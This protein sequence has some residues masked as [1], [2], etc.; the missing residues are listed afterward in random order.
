MAVT[1]KSTLQN[2]QSYLA[3]LG[4]FTG[5]VRIGEPVNPPEDW[6]AALFMSRKEPSPEGVTLTGTMD[7]RTISVRIYVSAFDE[8]LDQKEFDLDEIVN[9]VEEAL[10]THFTLG[11]TVRNVVPSRQGA[12]WGYLPI[13]RGSGGSERMY[14]VAEINVTVHID[15]NATFAA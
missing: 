7:W 14:R 8:P 4:Y 10:W 13:G 1:T 9:E 3:S 6:T 5:G 11:S 15:D 2:M 12:A